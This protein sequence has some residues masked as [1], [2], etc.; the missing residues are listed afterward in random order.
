MF[1]FLDGDREGQV[2]VHYSRW[3]E[4]VISMRTKSKTYLRDIQ[5]EDMVEG[6]LALCA[7][8]NA[9]SLY[10]THDVQRSRVNQY[11]PEFNMMAS[12][13]HAN[14][15]GLLVHKTRSSRGEIHRC[16]AKHFRSE[17]QNHATEGS[18]AQGGHVG[19][20]DQAEVKG[21]TWKVWFSTCDEDRE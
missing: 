9:A 15:C 20:K 14:S 21:L 3:R 7:K 2:D 1:F 16:I 17:V 19:Q 10:G 18:P 4:K 5:K 8:L 6:G 13:C 12:R 11:S